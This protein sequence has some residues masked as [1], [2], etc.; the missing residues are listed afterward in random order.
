MI[1]S[2]IVCHGV[3]VV[4]ISEEQFWSD[5]SPGGDRVSSPA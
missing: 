1:Y 3:V 5:L 4:A 2:Q